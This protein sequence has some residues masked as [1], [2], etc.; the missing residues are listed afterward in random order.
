MCWVKDALVLSVGTLFCCLHSQAACCHHSLLLL[1][2][3]YHRSTASPLNQ[4]PHLPTAHLVLHLRLLQLLAHLLLPLLT[5]P[6]PPTQPPHPTQAPP[7]AH[8]VLRL[9]LLQ[10]LAQLLLALL[11]LPQLSLQLAATLLPAGQLLCQL[12]NLRRSHRRC[13][14]QNTS[15]TNTL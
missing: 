10:L 12:L 7:L 15:V 2:A 3:H 4:R 1:A 14:A 11:G 8:L 5:L 9:R 6:H 13:T